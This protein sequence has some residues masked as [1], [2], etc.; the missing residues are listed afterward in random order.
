MDITDDEDQLP[1]PPISASLAGQVKENAAPPTFIITAPP[2]CPSVDSNDGNHSSEEELEEINKEGVAISPSGSPSGSPVTPSGP[3]SGSTSSNSVSSLSSSGGCD[4]SVRTSTPSDALT[5]GNADKPVEF[6][7]SPPTGIHVHK[8][9]RSLSPPPNVF[10]SADSIVDSA[11]DADN[12]PNNTAQDPAWPTKLKVVESSKLWCPIPVRPNPVFDLGKTGS[13]EGPT[14]NAHPQF[15]RHAEIRAEERRERRAISPRKR[16][17]H[18]NRIH[19]L[20]RPCL[21]FEKMQQVKHSLN[22][23]KQGNSAARLRSGINND[24]AT[25]KS[26]SPFANTS[27]FMS[28]TNPIFLH[29]RNALYW[30][31]CAIVRRQ[32]KNCF[33]QHTYS[34]ESESRNEKKG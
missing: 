33:I 20:Q 14:I 24:A 32:K 25:F 22:Q 8:P 12:Q 3:P 1:R 26:T 7:T 13:A 6:S 16:Y 19:H 34:T 10:S 11:H 4:G 21:D 9:R 30:H 5:C 17:R 29:V 28:G 23:Q 18:Q 27:D 31:F 2:I 15:S